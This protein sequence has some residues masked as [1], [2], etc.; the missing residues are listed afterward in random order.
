MDTRKHW[1]ECETTNSAVVTRLRLA[2]CVFAE[3]EAQLL[4]D[5]AQS[6][7]ELEAMVEQRVIGFPLEHIIGWAAFCGVKIMVEKGVFVPRHR[8][9]FLVRQATSLLQ[10]GAIVVDLCCGSGAIGTVLAARMNQIELHAAD[11]DPVAVK[12]ARRNISAFGGTV[13]EGDLY[14]PLPPQL[15]GGINILVANAPYVP[16][17]S[18]GTMPPEARLHEAPVA[19][20]G[21]ADGL[22]IQRRIASEAMLWLAPGGHLLVETSERQTLQTVRIFEQNGL[23]SRVTHCDELDATVVIGTKPDR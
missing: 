19:L 3:E 17:D 1:T 12:C 22:D 6:P 15:R 2:G 14:E 8:T 21:G 13:Y 23:H 10:N 18:I 4:A 16:T 11:I 7:V 5:A 20:D 9:E